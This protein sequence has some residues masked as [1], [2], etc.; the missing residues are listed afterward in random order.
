MS[1]P[2]L[3]AY[4]FEKRYNLERLRY[5]LE[6]A[7]GALKDFRPETID[8]AKSALETICKA[9][10]EDRGQEYKSPDGKFLELPKLIK[11]AC[12][13]L[14]ARTEQLVGNIT[15]LAQAIAE[16]RNKDTV[17]GHGLE[18]YRPMIGRTEINI[19]VSTF[20]NLVEILLSLEEAAGPDLARTK[21]SFD[22]VES[23]L[24]L[25]AFN[26]ELDEAISVRL[27]EEG[28]RNI[29]VGGKDLR[30]SFLMY[31]YDRNAYL[32]ELKAA[33]E[34][35]QENTIANLKPLIA[36]GVAVEFG[37][38]GRGADDFRIKEISIT[39]WGI[40][41]DLARVSG[42]VAASVDPDADGEFGREDVLQFLA[43]VNM[44]AGQDSMILDSLALT[45]A[46]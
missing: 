41:D 37:R 1:N 21:L 5:T 3:R 33:K 30:P 4:E 19:F 40:R 39:Q 18:G 23:G 13:A 8:W 44:S 10:L 14:G 9:I 32:Q 29:Y 16:M 42:S 31:Q 43:E 26:E 45:N 11:K 46:P 7:E 34:R 15:G 6:Q 20:A 36:E 24:D 38:L 35:W 28:D 25:A 22:E 12:T 2:F 17:A 27:G